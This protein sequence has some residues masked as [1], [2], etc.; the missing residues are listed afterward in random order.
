MSTRAKRIFTS[1]QH[2]NQFWK[3]S[4]AIVVLPGTK[5]ETS[6]NAHIA[7]RYATGDFDIKKLFY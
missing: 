4:F 2:Q 6:L 1:R 5:R 3:K 7:N